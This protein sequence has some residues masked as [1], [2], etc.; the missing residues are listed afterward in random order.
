MADEMK[1]F[2]QRFENMGERRVLAANQ[3]RLNVTFNGQNGDLP[4]AVAIDATDGD[5]KQIA[6]EAVRTGYI[7][8]VAAAP[9]VD[10]TNFVVERFPATPDLPARVMIRPKTPFGC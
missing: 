5:L 4:D 3:A 6:T 2:V 9:N 10:F 7:P 8:G 1:D